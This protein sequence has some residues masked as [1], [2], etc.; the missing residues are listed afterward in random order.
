MPNN[1]LI[2][3]YD[4]HQEQCH[5]VTLLPVNASTIVLRRHS[6]HTCPI[7]KQENPIT[8]LPIAP[9]EIKLPKTEEEPQPPKP[10]P[11]PP[12]V[13]KRTF[14]G[15]TFWNANT[16][17][18][19]QKII[20]NKLEDLRK[21]PLTR[22][23]NQCFDA[24]SSNSSNNASPMNGTTKSHPTVIELAKQYFV[25]SLSDQNSD[26]DR[27]SLDNNSVFDESTPPSS[28]R[29]LQ[30][31]SNRRTQRIPSD[32]NKSQTT[33][34]TGY[35]SNGSDSKNSTD[36]RSRFS[37]VDTQCSL[38]INDSPLPKDS[39]FKLTDYLNSPLNKYPVNRKQISIPQRSNGNSNP[40]PNP[41]VRGLGS[42]TTT[43]NNTSAPTNTTNTSTILNNQTAANGNVVSNN[44][45]KW[46]MLYNLNMNLNNAKKTTEMVIN[47]TKSKQ[48][49]QQKRQD[50]NLS[51][52][53]FSITSSPGY[54]TKS[55]E[56]PLLQYAAKINKNKLHHQNSSDSFIMTTTRYS[57]EP[58]QNGRQDS[59][60]SSDS[61]SQISS[62]GCNSRTLESSLLPSM[63]RFCNGELKLFK[64]FNIF[65]HL[66]VKVFHS[67]TLFIA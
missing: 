23:K 56:A 2:D 9:V 62:P 55:M 43:A 49:Q 63:K 26:D 44:N 1:S 67:K 8:T 53:S 16:I 20:M 12:P 22:I 46:N 34:D 10:L 42:T 60:L 27:M 32:S 38:D 24:F 40:T 28:A 11:P 6:S 59:S 17:Q 19:Q 35:M 31:I 30:A 58:I 15:K 65:L 18:N 64:Y 29:L 39:P 45:N 36:F 50:S 57:C 21:S 7:D 4:K 52:D 3:L 33:T 14:R 54:N 25:D 13:P 47:D 66:L 51:N 37:S 48:K 61:F 41:P 5:S